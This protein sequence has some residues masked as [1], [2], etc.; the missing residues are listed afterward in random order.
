LRIVATAPGYGR[1]EQMT[2][3]EIPAE[4]LTPGR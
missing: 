1:Y 3:R 4:R 2:D